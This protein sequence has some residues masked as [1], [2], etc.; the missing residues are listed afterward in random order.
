MDTDV[1]IAGGGLNGTSLAL[2]LAQHGLC[3]ALV[4]PVPESVRSDDAFDGRGY[5]LSIAS[6]R[7][8]AAIGIWPL[9]AQDSQPILH[10]Q[11]TDGR[12]GEGASALM[13]EFDHAEI[14]EGP[15]GYMLEDRRLRPALMAAVAAVP[16]IRRMTGVSVTDHAATASGVG[17][18]LSDGSA[19]TAAVL[20]GC[21]GKA[22]PTAKRCGIRRWGHDYGQTSL[23]CAV[24]H[25]RPHG[26]TA[27]QFFMPHG[28]LAILPLPGNRSSIVWTE[29][30]A[31]AARIA[32]LPDAD[33]LA[34][35]RPRF[36]SF[37]GEIALAGRRFSY[38]LSLSLAHDFIAERVALLGDAAHAVHPVAGQGLNAGLKDVGAL[39]EV[40][41]EAHRR[42]EDIGRSDVLKRYQ[43]WRHFDVT[44][45]ALATDATVRLFSNDNPLLRLGRDLGLSLV[46]GLA[47]L[48]RRLIRE[49]AGLEDRVPRLNR[50]LRL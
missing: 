24:D 23:V 31:D 4:D 3:V 18:T 35:L 43:R 22:S 40:L 48:R 17:V 34:E 8:L 32:T 25:E 2:S 15:M 33:F 37:L 21:D 36:G 19:L 46:N 44:R 50:G 13:L 27:Y 30:T 10:I 1:I 11:V 14:E 49:A 42:G 6:Q 41:V 45:L 47:P 38:P 5:A 26:G 7:L 29:T 28:P 39:T 9:V 20:V 16:G 12:A